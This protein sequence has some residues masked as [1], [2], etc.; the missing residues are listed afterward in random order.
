MS[1]QATSPTASA[2]VAATLERVGSRAIERDVELVRERGID[3]L[4][5]GGAPDLPLPAH[6]RAA[7]DA[8]LDEVGARPS[9]GLPDLRAA[10]ATT[11]AR[12]T[13]REV[14]PAREIVVTHGA[15][16]ALNVVMRAT[17]AAGDKVVVP[18]PNFFFDGV[19][20]LAGGIPVYVPSRDP[21]RWGPDMDGIARAV[22][23]GARMI[24]FSNP[25]NP[26][27]YL[28]PA[29]EL[30]ELVALAAEAGAVLVSDE[31]YDRMVYS[32]GSFTSILSAYREGTVVLVR[33]LSKGYAMPNWRVGYAVA[34]PALAADFVKV[35]EWDC[36][37]CNFVTQRAAAAAIAGPQ[38]WVTDALAGYER[39]RDAVYA[40]VAD[41][42][43]LSCARPDST[44]F[45]FLDVSRLEGLDAAPTELLL[46]AGIPTVAGRYFG[47]DDH[48]RM[49]FGADD[50]TIDRLAAALRAFRPDLDETGR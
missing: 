34:A 48:V 40:A 47:R 23:A 27:G 24:L 20:R 18:T 22:R 37:H 13:G 28:P 42:P 4:E 11:L 8:A 10:I 25:T 26:T 29:A 31:S 44:P 21:S 36:L 33:S 2:P 6:V 7:I 15:M 14:D 39:K 32:E 50:A 30:R 1:T 9:R 12:E 5:L 43:W 45:L 49:P 38:T 17:L 35:L 46:R 3:P 16:H 41:S 19:I